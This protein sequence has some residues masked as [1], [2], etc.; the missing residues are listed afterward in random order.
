MTLLD[1]PQSL[2]APV[3]A[4]TEHLDPRVET[5]WQ[6]NAALGWVV[7][8]LLACVLLLVLDRTPAWA[9]FLAPVAST[10]AM[11]VPARR[12]RHFTFR[13]S[14]VD[15]RVAHG[16][17]WRTE[18]VVLHSRIQHVDTRQ[19]PVERMMGLATVV[20]F[21]A[22]SVGAMVAIPGLAAARAEALRDELVRLSGTDDAV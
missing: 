8:I 14:E 1:D 13:V 5:L 16:W 22:G 6:I 4:E 7:W 2:P 9:T 18:S 21:T 12:Y 17:L 10:Y 19:G 15:V 3:E 20:V 11:A